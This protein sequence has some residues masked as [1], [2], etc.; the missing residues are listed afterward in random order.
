[1]KFNPNEYETVETRINRFYE[2]HNDGRIITEDLTS[3]HDREKGMWRIK[4]YI[5]LT[6]ADQAASLPKSTGHASEVDGQGMAQK[7]AAYEVCETSAIGRAL[8]NMNL[9]GSRRPSR[10][11]MEK[12]D[13]VAT[14]TDWLLEATKLGTVTDLRKLYTRANANGASQSELDEIRRYADELSAG[15]KPK[16]VS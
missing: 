5:Y 11:E 13:R 16:R 12:A 2:Q 15:S 1:M 4:A 7:Q 6:D 10:E 3:E 14:K 8:A 9:S